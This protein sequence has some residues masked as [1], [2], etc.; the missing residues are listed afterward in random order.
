MG[1]PQGTR[2]GVEGGEVREQ[3]VV[4]VRAKCGCH[5]VAHR[6]GCS[7]CQMQVC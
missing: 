6:S 2:M 1:V 3:T 4:V 7:Q 5:G